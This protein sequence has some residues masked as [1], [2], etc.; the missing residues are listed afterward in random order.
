MGRVEQ[1]TIITG[2]SRGI[3]A[4]TARRLAEDG[5]HIAI[6]YRADEASANRV[7]AQ[8]TDAGARCVAVRVDTAVDEDVETLFATAAAELGPITALVNNA[9]TTSPMGRLADLRPDDIRRVIDVNV[10]GALLCARVAA[11]TLTRGG[12]IVNLSSAAATLGSPG[13]Y[14]HYAASKAAIDA[15]TVGLAK[16]L[17]GDGIRVNGVAPGIVRTDIHAVSG[18]ADRPDRVTDRIPMR[19]AGEPP[20]IAE[21]IAWLLSPA[22]SYVTGATIR[23]AG[24]M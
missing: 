5:H 19:R 14:V 22:A 9:G 12:A 6:G 10:T 2:G 1:V 15:L 16:E 4:A 8:V 21:V 3:G 7:V 13:E 18:M 23:A 17:A 24:G 20:E 11:R